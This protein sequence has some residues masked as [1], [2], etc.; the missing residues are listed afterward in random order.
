MEATEKIEQMR[1]ALKMEISTKSYH[2]A[3]DS[4]SVRSKAI[5]DAAKGLL[6][7][8]EESQ[9]ENDA[10]EIAFQR[11]IERIEKLNSTEAERIIDEMVDHLELTRR[12]QR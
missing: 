2:A 6:E 8:A 7:V 11:A 1:D 12:G 9:R 4:L 10:L 3:V 5:E